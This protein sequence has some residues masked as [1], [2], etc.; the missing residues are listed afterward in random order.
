LIHCVI[1]PS[2]C[3]RLYFWESNSKLVDKNINIKAFDDLIF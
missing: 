1:C 3:Q 2:T